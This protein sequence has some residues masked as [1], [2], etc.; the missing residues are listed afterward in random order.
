MIKLCVPDVGEEEI[1][2]VKEVL[3]SKYLVQGS[4]VLEFENMVCEYLNVKHAIA[5]SSGTAALH[6][7]LLALNIKA[8][9]EVIV[10][11]FTFP[12]TA[13]VV[14]AVGATTKFVDIDLSTFCM[15]ADKI[16]EQITKKTK[17]IIPVQ[18]FGQSCEMSK[19]LKL[20]EKYNLNIIE[21]AACA[22]GAE[23]EGKKVGTIGDIGCF[24]L[25][26]RKAITTGEGG[27]VV[28]NDDHIADKVRTLRNHGISYKEEKVEF[29]LPGLNYRM[30]D[31]QGAIGVEQMKKL[32]II[33]SERK[34]IAL[35]YNR[36]LEKV[37]G[38]KTPRIQEE[39]NHVWQ[40]YHILIDEQ[41]NRNEIIKKL[42]EKGIETNFGA[43]TVHNQIYYKNKY[44]LSDSCF[45][46][47]KI[48]YEKGIALPL[49]ST[50]KIKEQVI[51]VKE[52]EKILNEQLWR[53][54]E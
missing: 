37:I 22:L 42:K 50:M 31:I 1:T 12:A 20:A 14:E 29:V 6:L 16:E 47:S 4:K 7:A 15:D 40:T 28:T 25:H 19:I 43:H 11:D 46:N 18:E 38:V 5:V 10:P 33:N 8:G 13:N 26:P 48:A 41:I 35:E 52:L 2:A 44:N 24:S 49:Y 39:C 51:V 54:T 34:R 27:I 36:L 3:E 53:Y 30:T 45:L 32:D 17:A 23:Y 21:D 9:D